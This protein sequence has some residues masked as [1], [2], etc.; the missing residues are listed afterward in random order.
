MLVEIKFVIEA[1]AANGLKPVGWGQVGYGV[2]SSGARDLVAEEWLFDRFRA[3]FTVHL[4]SVLE[5]G[6]GKGHFSGSGC[7]SGEMADAPDLG[8]G[9]VRGGGSSP[10]S[11]TISRL[12]FD[13]RY[14]N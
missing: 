7:A 10:L 2:D 12:Q 9:P 8:S 5:L 14:G 1:D 6:P 11:R 3:F 13:G 4:Y